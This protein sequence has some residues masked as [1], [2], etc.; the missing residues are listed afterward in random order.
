MLKTE[1]KDAAVINNVAS[2][3][4][5]P[6]QIRLPYPNADANTG[7]SRELPSGLRNRSGLKT[8]GS[9]YMEG[10]CKIALY[11]VGASSLRNLM[12]IKTM[13][14]HQVFP[15]TNAPDIACVNKHENWFEG[16]T[17]AP[18]GMK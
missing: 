8:S 7:S 6:G 4:Y 17:C 11:I 3:K 1:N 5:L 9:G 18:L 15:I 13:T 12:T 16:R 2:L 14:T 10:S